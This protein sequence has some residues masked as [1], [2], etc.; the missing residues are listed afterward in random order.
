MNVSQ[1]VCL[2]LSGLL[3]AAKINEKLMSDLEEKTLFDVIEEKPTQP[4]L[5]NRSMNEVFEDKRRKQMRDEFCAK[6]KLECE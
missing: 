3:S 4:L 1:A 5:L 6:Y 2:L